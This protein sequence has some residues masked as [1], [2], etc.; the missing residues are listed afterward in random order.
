MTIDTTYLQQAINRAADMIRQ[1]VPNSEV[2]TYIDPNLTTPFWWVYLDRLTPDE[3]AYAITGEVWP[4]NMRYVVGYVTEGFDGEKQQTVYT[5]LPAVKNYFDTHKR[6]I[7]ADNQATI[8]Y[9]NPHKLRIDVGSNFGL[10]SADKHIGI[11]LR[12]LLPFKI[13]NEQE[14]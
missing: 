3:Q 12:L 7:Y 10:F 8:P 6:L 1:A 14:Y 4:V 13:E 9:L 2:I 5:A 11:E